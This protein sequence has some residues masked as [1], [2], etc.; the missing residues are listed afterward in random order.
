LKAYCKR[1]VIN[2]DNKIKWSRD[3][4]YLT[5]TPDDYEIEN[6]VY[7]YVLMEN[8]HQMFSPLSRRDFDKYFIGIDEIRSDKIDKILG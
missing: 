7:I 5:M 3:K 6:G 2:E 4:Y 8:R 1:T